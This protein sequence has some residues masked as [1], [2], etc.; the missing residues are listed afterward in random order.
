MD[1][2]QAQLS[3]AKEEVEKYRAA[4]EKLQALADGPPAPA[5]APTPVVP[6]LRLPGSSAT[7]TQH[8]EPTAQPQAVDA[9]A[10]SAAATDSGIPPIQPAVSAAEIQQMQDQMHQQIMI[11][12]FQ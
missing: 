6:P 3:A 7:N 10:M 8:V 2:L 5:P 4:A 1:T 12:L 9:A 11:Q